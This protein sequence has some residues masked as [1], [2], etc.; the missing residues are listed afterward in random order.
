MQKKNEYPKYWQL[1]QNMPQYFPLLGEEISVQ[2]RRNLHYRNLG[3]DPLSRNAH[4]KSIS[5]KGS[6]RYA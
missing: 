1:C 5:G 6:A 3:L 2:I 4:H